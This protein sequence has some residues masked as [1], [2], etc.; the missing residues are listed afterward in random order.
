MDRKV[1]INLM[2]L[3]Y[4]IDDEQ[5]IVDLIAL[6]LE[7]SNFWVDG[8]LDATTF[9][10][11]LN[12]KIPDLIILD[13]MLSDQSGFEVCKYLKKEDRY[14]NIPIII[15]SALMGETEKILGLELGADDYI[16]KPFSPG[17]MVARVKA[18]LRRQTNKSREN[19]IIMDDDFIIETEKHRVFINKKEVPLTATEFKILS[20]LA[21]KQG[22]VFTRGQ[23]LDYLWGEEKAVL[24]RTIDVHIK[25]LREKLGFKRC[26]IKNIRG[27]GY[28]LEQ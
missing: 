7:R 13:L 11:Q 9:Y 4:V 14:S 17:E 27:I 25:N 26:L 1:Y 3:I 28:K 22:W 23:I 6:H 19:R 2:P 20:L 21:N 16:T 24:E 15:L 12:K 10:H 18:V 8:F 5:D